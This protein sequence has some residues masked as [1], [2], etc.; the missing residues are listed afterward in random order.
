MCPVESDAT[1]LLLA[2]EQRARR[3]AEA[4][5]DRTRRLQALTAMLSGA[6]ERPA[7]LSIMVDAGRGALGASAGFAWWLRDDDVVELAA[8]AHAGTVGRLD[9]FR[10][11]PMTMRIP[12]CDVIRTLQPLMFESVAAMVEG[13]PHIILPGGSPFRAW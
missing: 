4:A 6:V 3:L 11:F 9:E 12:V 2:A 1:E 13:Y 7:V 10:T 8:S 5:R